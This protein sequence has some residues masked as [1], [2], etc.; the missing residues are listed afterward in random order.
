ML[1]VGAGVEAAEVLELTAGAGLEAGDAVLQAE[2][3]R[4]VVADVEMEVTHV[5][6]RA[7]VAAVEHVALPHVERAGEDLAARGERRRRPDG[8]SSVDAGARRGRRSGTGAPHEFVDRRAVEREHR[9]KE[10]VGDRRRRG[11][12]LIV[13]SRS[14]SSRRSRRT[15]LRRLLRSAAEV[16]VEGPPARV[17]PLELIARAPDVAEGLERVGLV[18]L[19]EVD[20]HRRVALRAAELAERGRQLPSDRVAIGRSGARGNARPSPA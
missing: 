1:T 10:L 9:R 11:A 20:V 3:D 13:T 14:A 7:P 17:D 15:W 18:G 6:E 4:G 16:V 19:A 12:W 2:L 5:L 8:A